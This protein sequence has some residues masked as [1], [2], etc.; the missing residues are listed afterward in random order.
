MTK[1]KKDTTN[2]SNIHRVLKYMTK[3]EEISNDDLRTIDN[4]LDSK[5]Y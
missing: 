2:F 4:K 1:D 3:R 5:L